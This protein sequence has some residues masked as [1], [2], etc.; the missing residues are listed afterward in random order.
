M[1]DNHGGLCHSEKIEIVATL[2]VM[3]FR[4]TSLF[5]RYKIQSTVVSPI[6]I[7]AGFNLTTVLYSH[8]PKL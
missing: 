4:K 1:N 2:T 8:L 5:G 6:R 3:L 7:R